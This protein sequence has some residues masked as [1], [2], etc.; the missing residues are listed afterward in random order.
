MDHPYFNT[1]APLEA[2]APGTHAAPRIHG[3]L[4]G[5]PALVLLLVAAS[6]SPDTRGHGT[7]TQLGLPSCSM[8]SYTGYPCPSCGMTTSVVASVHGRL[9]EAFA[10]QPFGPVLV[11]MLVLLAGAGLVQAFTGRPALKAIRLHVAWAVVAF[12]G[13]FAGWGIKVA[14]GV[15]AGQYPL[16]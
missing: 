2:A 9:G 8:L 6:L 10:A 11:L 3:V 7:H 16:R 1:T 4:A 14:A 5:G 12:F 13:M 15:A